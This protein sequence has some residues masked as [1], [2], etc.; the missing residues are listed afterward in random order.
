MANYKNIIKAGSKNVDIK[1]I[2][3]KAEEIKNVTITC[4]AQE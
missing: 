2:K 3:Y 4:S 1:P